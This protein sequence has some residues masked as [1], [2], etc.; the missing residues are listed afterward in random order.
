M[1]CLQLAKE[2]GSVFTV[3]LGMKPTVVLYGYDV[4]KEALIDRGDEFS[5][6]TQ[7]SIISQ[8]NQGLG[9]SLCWGT[10]RSTHAAVKLQRQ[11]HL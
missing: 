3:Y 11:G 2:Y 10:F 1:L 6:K 9:M 7:S 5:G 4:L 8:V